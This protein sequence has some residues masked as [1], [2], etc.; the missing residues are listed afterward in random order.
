MLNKRKDSLRKELLKRRNTIMKTARDAPPVVRPV[1]VASNTVNR[2]PALPLKPA[3]SSTSSV[4][5]TTGSPASMMSSQLYNLAAMAASDLPQSLP[6]TVSKHSLSDIGH[7]LVAIASTN[8]MSPKRKRICSSSDSVP[9][10]TASVDH[11]SLLAGPTAGGGGRGGILL[12]TSTAGEEHVSWTAAVTTAFESFNSPGNEADENSEQQQQQQQ[13]QQPQAVAVPTT[14]PKPAMKLSSKSPPASQQT[15]K[16]VS[17]PPLATSSTVG[18]VSST[19]SSPDRVD[20]TAATSTAT[21]MKS[22]TP[23]LTNSTKDGDVPKLLSKSNTVAKVIS[24]PSPVK[25]A[26]T[27]PTWSIQSP[28]SSVATLPLV[29]AIPSASAQVDSAALATT[30]C[31]FVSSPEAPPCFIDNNQAHDAVEVG[32][33]SP[34][35]DKHGKKKKKKKKQKTSDE[36]EQR[37]LEELEQMQAKKS[38]MVAELIEKGIVNQDTSLDVTTAPTC[39]HGDTTHTPTTKSK[40]KSSTSG[41]KSKKATKDSDG[42][43]SPPPVTTPKKS[44]SSTSKHSCGRDRNVKFSLPPADPI[45][46]ALSGNG[47][48]TGK[49][50]EISASSAQEPPRLL[51]PTAVSKGKKRKAD[52]SAGDLSPLLSL[53]PAAKKSRRVQSSAARDAYLLVHSAHPATVIPAIPVAHATDESEKTRKG[54][55]KSSSS[56]STKSN[57]QSPAGHSCASVTVDTSSSDLA[58]EL[59]TADTSDDLLCLCRTPYDASRYVYHAYYVF[60]SVC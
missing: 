57:I 41:S 37:L 10:G 50:I 21:P 51:S 32:S 39:S 24:T 60:D 23:S 36:E 55:R 16:K 34:K 44:K 42:A 3:A 22:L 12:T 25:H 47:K 11:P 54:V 15:T 17:T 1:L 4:S 52:S 2:L 35:K 27:M 18:T 33:N 7:P 43:L 20:N 6:V 19:I 45:F 38:R 59:S 31:N 40:V 56:K 13:Q 8:A 58:M 49:H 48:V 30:A 5:M 29:S 9:P 46:S 53:A 14:P 28:K 26:I